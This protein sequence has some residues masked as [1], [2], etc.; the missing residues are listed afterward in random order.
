ME[1]I[2]P[3]WIAAKELAIHPD[4][5]EGP[6]DCD[7]YIR[8]TLPCRHYLLRACREGFP[9]PMALLHPRWWL[10]GPLGA[11]PNWRPRYYD[12]TLDSDDFYPER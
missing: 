8:W 3:E 9:I 5:E 1:K 7:I 11:P 6:C 2:N 12:Q 10:D 4:I